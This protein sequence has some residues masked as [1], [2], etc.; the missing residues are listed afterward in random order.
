MIK[1]INKMDLS[2]SHKNEM[3][4]KYG[5]QH[6]MQEKVAHLSMC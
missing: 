4:Q 3:E 5:S 1:A 6:D 2:R